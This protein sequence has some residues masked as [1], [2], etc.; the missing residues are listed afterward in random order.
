[1]LAGA[2]RGVRVL[3]LTRLLPGPFLTMVL[4]DLGADVV[5]VEDPRLGDYMRALPPKRDGLGGRYAAV[6]RG[7][8]S[9]ILDLKDPA[10]HGAFLRMCERADVVV[11]G[12]RPGVMARLGLGYEVLSKKHPGLILCSLT[13]YGQT[14]PYRDRAGHD[15][16]YVGLTGVLSLG[17]KVVPGMQIGDLAGGSMWGLSA[18]LAALWQR[19]KNGGQ[20]IHLDI[21]MTEGV[22]A[23]LAAEFGRAWAGGKTGEGLLTGGHACYGL[24]VT[25]DGRYLSLGAL[26]PKFWQAFNQAIGRSSSPAELTMPPSEQ[27]RIRKEI[28]EIL[29]AAPL[30]TWQER[31]RGVDACCEPVLELDE[32]AAFPHHVARDLFFQ[33]EG[34]PIP[35]LKTPLARPGAPRSP[36][37]HGEHT[38]EVLSEYGFSETE[39]SALAPAESEPGPG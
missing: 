33:C 12:F 18:I 35:Q 21:S 36:P 39:V 22:L 4:A 19:E 32:V 30:A 15:L 31:L 8:R 38:R 14:G 5:K 7:K 34:V 27:T 29:A 11:E 13:G 26:E 10:A 6:N 23:F 2:L 17:A 16:N 28:Q 24:Y 37:A 3:D 20:G 1:M 9:I 25:G